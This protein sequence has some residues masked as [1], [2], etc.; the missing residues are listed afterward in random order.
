MVNPPRTQGATLSAWNPP[1]VTS[2]ALAAHRTTSV[3]VSFSPQRIWARYAPPAA[4]AP[5]EPIPLQGLMPFLI[6]SSIPKSA[7]HLRRTS[8]AAIP[9]EFFSGS[10]GMLSEPGPLTS[11]MTMPDSILLPSIVSKGSFRANPNTSK[12]APMLEVVAGA[13]TRIHSSVI[14]FMRPYRCA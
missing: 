7:P 9:T 6:L 14:F 2:S 12:P 11:D 4:D 5:E 10:V 8:A 3:G 13:A 1:D